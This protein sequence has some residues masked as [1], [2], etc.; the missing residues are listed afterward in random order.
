MSIESVFAVINAGMKIIL[1]CSCDEMKNRWIDRLL[2]VKLEHKPTIGVEVHQVKIDDKT[3]EIWNIAAEEKNAGLRP[4]YLAGAKEAILLYEEFI[5]STEHEM[6]TK[7][8]P[9]MSQHN[10]ASSCVRAHADPRVA[11]RE[12][13][14]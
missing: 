13:L 9:M 4:A 10:I 12:I 2:N 1:A 8:L 11:I 14:E 5:P 6:Y 7:W 3:V